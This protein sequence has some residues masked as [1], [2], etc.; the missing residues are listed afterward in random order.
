MNKQLRQVI[1]EEVYRVMMEMG[2]DDPVQLGKSM[3]DQAQETL[4]TLEDELKY[5]EADIRVSNLPKQ[6]KEAR[7]EIA[8]LTKQKVERL[9]RILKWQNNLK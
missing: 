1:K 3:V 2:E 5:R 8:K 6:E 9:K 7:Q 4:D